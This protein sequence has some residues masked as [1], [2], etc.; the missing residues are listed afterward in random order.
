LLTKK[1]NFALFVKHKNYV[2]ET[3][4]DICFVVS[5]AN[6]WHK[7]EYANRNMRHAQNIFAC[8]IW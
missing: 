8:E 1:E 5:Y 4:R 3:P 2:G 7:H 6:W